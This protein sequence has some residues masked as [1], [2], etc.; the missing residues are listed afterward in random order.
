MRALESV[1]HPVRLRIVRR[2]ADGALLA[3][4]GLA[5]LLGAALARAGPDREQLRG[6][7]RD[8]GRYLSGRPGRH[9]VAT[10]LAEVL[11][12]LGIGVQLT[13]ATVELRNCPCRTI[14]PDRPG[15]LACLTEGVVDGVL[16]AC[17]AG[18]SIGAAAH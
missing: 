1:A 14:A 9:D 17:Q 10:K 13:G 5:Q 18:Q 11:D 15:L 8:W 4:S 7:W 16:A 6:T 3:P 12:H 2:L